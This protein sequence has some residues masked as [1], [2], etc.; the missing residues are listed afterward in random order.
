MNEKITELK[1]QD[2]NCNVFSVYDY[3][4]LSMNELL[5]QF[6][7]K[8]NECI[9]TSNE[10]ID[11]TKWL[12][13]EGLTQE[14]VKKLLSWLEDG[15]LETVI[16][17]NI[18]NDLS[19]KVNRLDKF[20]IR[21]NE[22]E[23]IQ[24]AIDRAVAVGGILELEPKKYDLNKQI[25][26]DLSKCSVNGNGAIFDFSKASNDLDCIKI[27]GTGERPYY[28]NGNFI[29]NIEMKGNRSNLGE[30]ATRQC[31]IFIEGIDEDRSSSHLVLEGL[32]IH[33][34]YEGIK[35]GSYTYLV[36]IVNTD[37]FYSDYCIKINEGLDSGENILF[38]KCAL[39]NSL[40]CIY[41]LNEYASITFNATSIDYNEHFTYNT[42]NAPLKLIGCHVEGD[43]GDFI[44]NTIINGSHLVLMKPENVFKV[45]ENERIIIS[46]SYISVPK[47]S[48]NMVNGE[49]VVSFN[50]CTYEKSS[51]IVDNDLNLNSSS[52][53]KK[54]FDVQV[55]DSSGNRNTKWSCTDG[56]VE[57]DFTYKE[58]GERSLKVIKKTQ[59]NI[60][61]YLDMLFKRKNPSSSKFRIKIRCKGNPA[62]PVKFTARPCSPVIDGYNHYSINK[63]DKMFYEWTNNVN[64][65]W[66]TIHITSASDS[67]EIS[68]HVLV[69]LFLENLSVNE[70]IWIDNV[71]FYEY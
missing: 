28:Q 39:Y 62:I 40:Y 19:T 56:Y 14:V 7:N 37:V 50:N 66:T 17:E 6:F 5:C 18:F 20:T 21:I 42:S 2:L 44:G 49:G 55:S 54:E 63:N 52:V 43:L 3:D 22:G 33:N 4:G 60:P 25:V 48:V 34:F 58:T 26:I 45:K 64:S 27:I 15:T 68:S 41:N 9:K 30:D 67:M 10:T 31:A 8:I 51:N 70:N 53:Y 57:N 36:R 46:D 47:K 32:N 29:K 13:N 59:K 12:V 24:T 23:S 11:L 71:E 61:L 16:N 1:K 35:F 65:E 38:D 69:T